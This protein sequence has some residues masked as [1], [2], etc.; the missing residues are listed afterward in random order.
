M[1]KLIK[2]IPPSGKQVK[3][4]KK[5]RPPIIPSRKPSVSSVA[6]SK[7]ESK[8][9]FESEALGFLHRMKNCPPESEDH[10]SWLLFLAAS[11]SSY[12]NAIGI[13]N[14]TAVKVVAQR[15]LS[16]P[17]MF[18]PSNEAFK[19]IKS[20]LKGIGLGT[21]PIVPISAARFNKR[22]DIGRKWI[23]DALQ[24]V[25]NIQYRTQHENAHPNA[26]KAAPRGLLALILMGRIRFPSSH[27]EEKC[28]KLPKLTQGNRAEWFSVVWEW[29]KWRTNDDPAGEVEL[30]PYGL[31]RALNRAGGPAGLSIEDIRSGLKRGT[32][33]FEAHVDDGIS[34]ALKQIFDGL[35]PR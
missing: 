21:A 26:S 29:I 5:L 22:E 25:S 1:K 20:Y 27:F 8:L 11:S 7:K 23:F 17:V 13:H 18:P 15:H 34:K 3:K 2:E 4:R 31:A 10:I 6:L 12:L 19:T 32:P 33:T 16:W 30:R 28:L 14:P 35:V 24:Y 9:S